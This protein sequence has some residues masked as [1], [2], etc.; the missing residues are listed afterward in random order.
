MQPIYQ[1]V[2]FHVFSSNV[3][4]ETKGLVTVKC[5]KIDVIMVTVDWH[6]VA[7]IA[8]FVASNHNRPI[9]AEMFKQWVTTT[10]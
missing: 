7:C 8:D 10:L 4:I 3:V 5:L 2:N 6:L 9:M 1:F